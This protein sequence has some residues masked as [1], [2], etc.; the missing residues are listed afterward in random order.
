MEL[1]MAAAKVDETEIAAAAWW[2]DYEA[3]G[4]A[5]RWVSASVVWTEDSAVEKLADPKDIEMEA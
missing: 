2:G 5:P 4:M 3:D 1:E